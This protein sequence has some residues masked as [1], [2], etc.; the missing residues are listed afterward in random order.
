M[1]S[2]ERGLRIFLIA[3]TGLYLLFLIQRSHRP[4]YYDQK[5]EQMS[6]LFTNFL[7]C[8]AFAKV[9]QNITAEGSLPLFYLLVVQAVFV[10]TVQSLKRRFKI[11]LLYRPLI[12]LKTDHEV[13]QH[14]IQLILCLEGF[15][16][17]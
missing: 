12:T 14:I 5:I 1:D 7:F 16:Q 6:Q 13:E 8:F 17:P 15:E 11:D 4:T 2:E 9:L 3:A 10:I